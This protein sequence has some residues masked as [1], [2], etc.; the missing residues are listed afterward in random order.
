M[1]L[2]ESGAS[3]KRFCACVGIPTN[4]AVDTGR[5]DRAPAPFLRF[6]L[7]LLSSL[8]LLLRRTPA[9]RQPVKS[10]LTVIHS[11]F[12]L[13]FAF[14]LLPF[15]SCPWWL[16]SS[17]PASLLQWSC[18]ALASPQRRD[19]RV[20]EGARLESVYTGNRIVGSN[21]T[22]SASIFAAWKPRPDCGRNTRPSRFE[23]HRGAFQFCL[24]PTRPRARRAGTSVS[25]M[26]F[27]ARSRSA[28]V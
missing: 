26:M 3:L 23:I 25:A 6:D 13:P 27:K 12:L 20:A 16:D 18:P 10:Q 7:F 19:G 2:P 14:F 5:P 24:L 4:L 9:L 17:V 22:L 8:C 11:S 15:P 1:L 21:P 28:S